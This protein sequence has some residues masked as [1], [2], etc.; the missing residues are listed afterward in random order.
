MLHRHCDTNFKELMLLY[1]QGILQI[2]FICLRYNLYLKVDYI[3][4]VHL[5]GNVRISTLCNYLE[6]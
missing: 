5:H 2:Q 1:L 3:V 6:S 4:Y